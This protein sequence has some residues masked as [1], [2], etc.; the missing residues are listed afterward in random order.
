MQQTPYFAGGV[1]SKPL[2][3][4]FALAVHQSSRDHV[5]SLQKLAGG[6]K[7]KM[8]VLTENVARWS[9]KLLIEESEAWLRAT[10]P[11]IA[12]YRYTFTETVRA[13]A[14][15]FPEM[16]QRGL[17]IPGFCDFV[18]HYLLTLFKD[19]LV[20]SGKFTRYDHARTFGI[21]LERLGRV[22]SDAVMSLYFPQYMPATS[23]FS[24]MEPELNALETPADA[25]PIVQ[26]HIFDLEVE[27]DLDA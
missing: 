15:V 25:E 14:K 3:F 19:P 1:F 27:T 22:I 24:R 13:Y 16:T 12:L 8:I 9:R 23:G 26:T 20:I 2:C 21:V 11:V 17:N 6:N 4:E 18:L 7:H 5:E 10:P